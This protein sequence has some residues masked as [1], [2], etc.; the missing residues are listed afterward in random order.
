MDYEQRVDD[1]LEEST[2]RLTVIQVRRLRYDSGNKFEATWWT[3]TQDLA[4]VATRGRDLKSR[5]DTQHARSIETALSGLYSP[6]FSYLLRPFCLQPPHFRECE[7][8]QS[9]NELSS[10]D[11]PTVR[12]SGSGRPAT[13]SL[14]GEDAYLTA[15][16]SEFMGRRII[17]QLAKG[18]PV[19]TLDIVQRHHDVS[20]YSGD[21]VDDRDMLDMLNTSATMCTVHATLLQRGTKHPSVY[22][23]VNVEGT[24]A[25]I[26]AA[27]AAGVC[28]LVYTSSASAVF[29]GTGVVEV[30][31][32][33]SYSHR[34]F[35]VYNPC[36]YSSTASSEPEPYPESA[37]A[38]LRKFSHCALPPI[39]AATKYHCG[40]RSSVQP[41]GPYVTPTP[42][43]GS[44]LSAFNT[45]FDPHGLEHPFIHFRI[46]GQVFC[47]AS[48]EAFY[49]WDITGLCDEYEQ[50]LL[51][52]EI[53][54]TYERARELMGVQSM[55]LRCTT[56]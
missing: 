52:L 48:G 53:P 4:R 5:R 40:L 24:R 25:V 50:S 36:S 56:S 38:K 6:S 8:L 13:T 18:D 12:R 10:V 32:R 16:R 44:I 11:A 45:S 23:K 55:V 1:R 20:F 9:I 19:S 21:I 7:F 34:P 43:A 22:I 17:E 51:S 47:V 27:I 42:N 29:N 15:D 54:N 31:R 39:H 28:R 41:L 14:Q 37:T 33:T 49:F 35:D 3:C 2:C 30:D 46:E 26:D